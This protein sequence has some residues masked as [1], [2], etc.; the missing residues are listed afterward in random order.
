MAVHINEYFVIENDNVAEINEEQIQEKE[1]NR[2]IFLNHLGNNFL[3]K[4]YK[5]NND[6]AKNNDFLL[7]NNSNNRNKSLKEEKAYFKES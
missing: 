1:K 4:K 6:V 3:G 5:D 2:K 7:Y